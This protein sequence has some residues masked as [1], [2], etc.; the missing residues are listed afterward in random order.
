MT[1]RTRGTL[2]A[3]LLAATALLVAGAPARA[4]GPPLVGDTWTSAVF[5]TTARFHAEINP[6]EVFTTYHFDYIKKSAYDAN[7]AAAK[8]GFSGASRIPSVTNAS[9]G[10]GGSFVTVTQLPFGL[11][12]NTA[13]RYR[14]VAQNAE[15]TVNGA[16]H[17]FKTFPGSA[18]SVLADGRGWEMVSPVDK[19]GGRVEAPGAIAGGGVLQ[20]ASQGG[21]VTYGSATSFAGGSGA[22]PASQYIGRRNSGGWSTENIT[23]PIFSGTYDTFDEGAPYQLF[24][25]DLGRGILLNGDHCRGETD[26]CAVANPP[27]AGTTAPAGYQNYYL[28]QSSGA[29]TALLRSADI[30]GLDLDP[31][32]FDLRLA[33]A[34]PDLEHAVLSTCTA[35]TAN[36]TEVP[37][38]EG[39]DPEAPNLYVSSGSGLSLVNLLPGE[40][41]GT[42]GAALGAQS[43][44]VS[45]NASRV[46]WQDL[47][48]GNLYLRASGQTKQADE[49]AGG[50]GTFET[51]SSDG[52]VAFFTVGEHLWRYLAGSDSATDITPGGGVQGVLGASSTGSVVYFQDGAGLKRWSSGSTTTIAPGAAA[53]DPGNW[54]PTT[55]T[56]RVS[57]DGSRLLFVSS[58]PLTG[59]DNT[60][61]KTKEPNTEVFLYDGALRCVSCNP[62]GARPIGASSIPGSIPNGT[63]PLSTD[64]YKPRNLSADGLRVFFDS[65]DALVLADTNES[66]D[67]YQ[68]QAQGKGS[69]K[70]A[71]GCINL[72]SS[73]RSAGGG[74]FVDASAGGNDAFFLTGGSLVGRD[75][76]SV[77]LY[78]ARVGGG[79]PEPTDPIPCK[80]DA[81]QDLPSEPIDP[82]LTTLLSGPGNP[83]VRYEG[84]VR[85]CG[86]IARGARRL[87]RKGRKARQAAKRA[88]T[89]QQAR[90]QRARAKKLDVLAKRARRS[91][92]AC[93]QAKRRAER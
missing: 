5:S 61:L 17:D 90:H 91:A 40:G 38:G 36:A 59:F 81:C 34:A 2:C 89:K 28:R 13:Y 87:A 16:V 57:A 44:A 1:G 79:F 37:E 8:D 80:G 72:L 29:Y 75:P 52:S 42:T 11:S 41:T 68:W 39:C 56:T 32:L 4:A 19:N 67:P 49:D 31:A 78:D 7:V 24:A 33:G 76:G 58:E 54:P 48:G 30:A 77:D 3:A 86:A 60:D 53:A 43:G 9:I 21:S 55:G 85:N 82:T 25:G 74:T 73:G 51:A 83:P 22:P 20:A 65:A 63:A 84:T 23:A 69:C 92:R 18:G 88:K 35:L 14:V 46:Y 70:S 45:D 93:K 50:G 15:G 71:G 66:V 62:S 47:T 64:A 6:N 10:S 12:A 26:G 27:L